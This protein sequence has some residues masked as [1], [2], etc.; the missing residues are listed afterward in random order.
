MNETSTGMQIT[1]STDVMALVLFGLIAI[2]ILA[3]AITVILIYRKRYLRNR[4][5]VNIVTPD[6]KIYS[7]R[8]KNAEKLITIDKK[9]YKFESDAIILRTWGREIYYWE[10]IPNPIKFSYDKKD[11]KIIM[12]SI[13]LS[14]IIDEKVTEKILAEKGV[15]KEDIFLFIII[16]LCAFAIFLLWQIKSSGVNIASTPENIG[17][18]KEIFRS[19]VT[20]S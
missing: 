1:G 9:K 6:G 5:K 17:L 19:V 15:N 12:S 13:E 14:S 8:I 20:G 11:S 3:I 2:F 16:G 18:L 7:E 4:L 10:G